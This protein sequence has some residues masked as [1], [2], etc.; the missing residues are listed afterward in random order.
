LFRSPAE[1]SFGELSEQGMN[2]KLDPR[3]TMDN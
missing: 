2:V 3:K 1:H